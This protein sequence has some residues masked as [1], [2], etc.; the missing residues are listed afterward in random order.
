[1]QRCLVNF[2]VASRKSASRTTVVGFARLLPA[3]LKHL[4]FFTGINSANTDPLFVSEIRP[5]NVSA[6]TIPKFYRIHR[7]QKL[8]S[9]VI[10]VYSEVTMFL[11]LFFR[12]YMQWTLK[13]TRKLSLIQSTTPCLLFKSFQSRKLCCPLSINRQ[14]RFKGNKRKEKLLFLD[15]IRDCRGTSVV[16]FISCHGDYLF[17]SCHSDCLGTSVLQ[18]YNY[19]KL[20]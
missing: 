7:S 14:D 15:Y 4:P 11:Y 2:Y 18:L 3:W 12:N 17:I 16:I 9:Q 10:L 13:R 20:S 5:L 1:M 6:R 8:D 19:F